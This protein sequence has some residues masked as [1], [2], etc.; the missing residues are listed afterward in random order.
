MNLPAWRQLS[1]SSVLSVEK[2]APQR[3]DSLNESVLPLRHCCDEHSRRAVSGWGGFC[4]GGN[5]GLY[6]RQRREYSSGAAKRDKDACRCVAVG[7]GGADQ[8]WRGGL[9]LVEAVRQR[10]ELTR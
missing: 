4:V 9:C 7:Y 5:R 1:S 10:K 8:C 2:V 6:E 3:Y